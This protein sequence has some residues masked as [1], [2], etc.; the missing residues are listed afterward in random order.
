MSAGEHPRNFLKGFNG[1]LHVDGYS[2]YHKVQNITLVGCWAHVRRKYDEA[3]KAMPASQAK[4]GT[5]AEQGLQ[6][7]NQLFAIE[8]ELKDESP[9]V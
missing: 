7:C 2:G 5:V 4:T 6:F 9:E 1:Y 8:R 3:L